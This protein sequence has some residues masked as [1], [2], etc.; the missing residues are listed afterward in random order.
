MGNYI[1]TGTATGN[2]TNEVYAILDDGTDMTIVAS[3]SVGGDVRHIGYGSGVLFVGHSSTKV[4]K[5]L[6]DGS[7]ITIDT[8]WGTAGTLD[9]GV[10][11]LI[12]G[13]NVDATDRADGNGASCVLVST[14]GS[15]GFHCFRFYKADGTLIWA[16]GGATAGSSAQ[17]ASFVPSNGNIVVVRSGTNGV[18]LLL[19]RSNGATLKTIRDG[20]TTYDMYAVDATDSYNYFITSSTGGLDQVNKY[21]YNPTQ[22]WVSVDLNATP[23]CVKKFGSYVYAGMSQYIFKLDDTDGSTVDTLTLNGNVYSIDEY[24][25]DLLVSCQ[26]AVATAATDLKHFSIR[27]IGTNLA[28]K[29]G[30]YLD[31]VC[32]DAIVGP[33]TSDVVSKTTVWIGGGNVNNVRFWKLIDN[34]SSLSCVN[35]LST[36]D[37]PAN[38]NSLKYC[39]ILDKLYLAT[40]DKIYR[41]NSDLSLDTSW[42][43]SGVLDLSSDISAIWDI[44]VDSSGYLA[45]ACDDSTVPIGH[46][47]L[48]DNTGTQVWKYTAASLDGGR[49]VSF[50][51]NG[52]VLAGFDANAGTVNIVR[53][54]LRSN[55]S[56]VQSGE[57]SVGALDRVFGVNSEGDAGGH[58]GWVWSDSTQPSVARYADS[59]LAAL[60]TTPIGTDF[61]YDILIRDSVYVSGYKSVDS[62][63]YYTIWKL[64]KSNGN[65]LAAYR[66][67]SVVSDY[68]R[69]LRGENDIYCVGSSS[70]NQDGITESATVFDSDLVRKYGFSTGAGLVTLDG[71]FGISPSITDQ[72]GDTTIPIGD[73]LSL[74]VVAEGTTPLN[75]QWYL[76]GDAIVGETND[77]YEKLVT[78]SSDYGI[79]TCEVTNAVGSVTSSNINVLLSPVISAQTGSSTV[80]SGY[81]VNL[82]VTASGGP[83]PTYQWYLNG[84]IIAG[85]TNSTYSYYAATTG[86]YKCR[87][88]NAGG[89]V[90]S[91]D[92]VKTVADNPYWNINPFELQWNIDRL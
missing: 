41:Y 11:H 17:G 39:S 58:V 1:F 70:V 26:G 60:W 30:I 3:A 21:D 47:F 20:T 38:I 19:N 43:V 55:G 73:T 61:L 46:V 28:T 16:V 23:L 83:T 7:T 2:G 5:F 51:T 62:A 67:S 56:L 33:S 75:Y 18:T 49:T 6:W 77:T 80:Y 90:D 57:F 45:I 64:D 24:G 25:S 50:L 53:Q 48:F 74:F 42:A 89:Y 31:K 15:T 72:S 85:A 79:Y 54:I 29:R 91:S 59:T 84:N 8:S 10:G 36:S 87:V 66:T 76:N 81:L 52:D 92:I 9:L 35:N 69:N 71:D 82:S 44:D 78:N 34:G 14:I 32:Y 13:I 68:V 27:V 22:Q 63:P 4:S 88:T 65:V 86:T 12:N 37:L 40:A